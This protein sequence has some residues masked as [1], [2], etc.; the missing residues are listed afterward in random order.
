MPDLLSLRFLP[1]FLPYPSI[2][3]QHQS[4][5]SSSFPS[6]PFSN[7]SSQLGFLDSSINTARSGFQPHRLSR[8]PRFSVLFSF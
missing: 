5:H 2:H 7:P 3:F 1:S 4:I 6:S 8:F